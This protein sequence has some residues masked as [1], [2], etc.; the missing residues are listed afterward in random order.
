MYLM[1]WA[2]AM[3]ARSGEQ[4]K[5]RTLTEGQVGVKRDQRNF[6]SAKAF[7]TMLARDQCRAESFGNSDRSTAEAGLETSCHVSNNDNLDDLSSALYSQHP[8]GSA[9]RPLS[10]RN[11]HVNRCPVE[12][13]KHKGSSKSTYELTRHNQT[14]QGGKSAKNSFVMRADASMD[15]SLGHSPDQINS[16]PISRQHTATAHGS[17]NVRLLNAG[18]GPCTLNVLGS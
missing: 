13:C 1:P 16:L 17:K 18:F 14:I 7:S 8:E 3:L 6:L 4:K 2:A 11:G 12:G 5:K 10:L 15:A 9:V